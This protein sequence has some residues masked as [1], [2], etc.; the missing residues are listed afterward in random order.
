M[1]AMAFFGHTKARNAKNRLTY[2]ENLPGFYG[3]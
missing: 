1:D 3:I 2:L